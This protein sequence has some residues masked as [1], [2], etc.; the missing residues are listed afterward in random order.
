MAQKYINF[1]SPDLRK[2]RMALARRDCPETRA[3]YLRA[4]AASARTQAD[5]LDREANALLVADGAFD[6]ADQKISA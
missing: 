4:I 1:D 5:R 2:A 6:S 3:A